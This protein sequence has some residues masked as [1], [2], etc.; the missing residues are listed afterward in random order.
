VGF[1]FTHKATMAVPGRL[2]EQVAEA[3]VVLVEFAERDAPACRLE[4]PI[5]SQILRRYADRLKV[6]QADVESSPADAAAFGVSAVPTFVLFVDGAEKFRLSGYQS[7][8]TL[9]AALDEAL[10]PPG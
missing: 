10:P 9:T 1:H 4:E 6:I 3:P 2:A 8:D 5:L 7:V